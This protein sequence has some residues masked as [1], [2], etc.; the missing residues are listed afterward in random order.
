MHHAVIEYSSIKFSV[1]NVKLLKSLNK[2]SI[3][4][5]NL[6]ASRTIYLY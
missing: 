6:E 5:S 4:D 3:Y 2:L 1:N